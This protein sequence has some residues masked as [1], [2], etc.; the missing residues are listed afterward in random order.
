MAR[1]N[2]AGHRTNPFDS[3]SSAEMLQYPTFSPSVFST[4]VSPSQDVSLSNKSPIKSVLKCLIG[5]NSS[6]SMDDF[7]L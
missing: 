3:H 2:A 7:G 4:V 5:N 1:R 6:R